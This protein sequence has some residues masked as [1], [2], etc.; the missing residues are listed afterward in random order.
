M[1]YFKDCLEIV[2]MICFIFY[3]YKKTF[4]PYIKE[5]K[6][7]E[8]PQKKRKRIKY[9]HRFHVPYKGKAKIIQYDKKTAY[10]ESAWNEVQKPKKK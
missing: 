10:I 4:K 1:S 8:K 7:K 2:T 3:M 9:L 5:V 6:K